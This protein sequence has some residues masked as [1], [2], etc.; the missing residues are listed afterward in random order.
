MDRLKLQSQLDH[1]Y[2]NDLMYM[3]AIYLVYI[4]LVL[5]GDLEAIYFNLIFYKS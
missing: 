2:K 3:D 4:K 5:S 1:I